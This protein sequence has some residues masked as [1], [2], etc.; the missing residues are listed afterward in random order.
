M[1]YRAFFELI[2]MG[3]NAANANEICKILKYIKYAKYVRNP[4]GRFRSEHTVTYSL[5][6]L[7]P[8]SDTVKAIY[9][10]TVIIFGVV[11]RG[12]Y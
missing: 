4:T 1:V 11:L 9:I 5:N 7:S 12:L 8:T 10:I 6:Q 3:R 2:S